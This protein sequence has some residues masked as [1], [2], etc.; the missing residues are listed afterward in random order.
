[1]A[2]V[3]YSV[4]TG[5]AKYPRGVYAFDVKKNNLLWIFEIGGPPIIQTNPR[6]DQNG[7]DSN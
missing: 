2:E 6:I 3:I 5:Y 4:C 1:M 7:G